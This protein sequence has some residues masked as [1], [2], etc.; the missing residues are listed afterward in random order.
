MCSEIKLIKL[1]R[2]CGLVV[3]RS[4]KQLVI[5]INNSPSPRVYPLLT[6][7]LEKAIRVTLSRCPIAKKQNV[8]NFLIKISSQHVLSIDFLCYFSSRV[9][10]IYVVFLHPPSDVET[11]A[12]F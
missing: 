11:G 8:I 6:C 12:F 4:Y 3:L 5:A 1:E 10:E 7:T 9:G 2:F